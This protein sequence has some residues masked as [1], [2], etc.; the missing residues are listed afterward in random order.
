MGEAY[1]KLYVSFGTKGF[2]VDEC[3]RVLGG[4]RESVRVLMSRLASAGYADRI[5][6]GEYQ[7]VHPDEI[8][9]GVSGAL[10]PL[11]EIRQREYVPILRRMLV[12]LMGA[13]RDRLASVV[14]FGSIARGRAHPF[15]DVDVLVV[16]DGMPESLSD[17]AREFSGINR[18]L[19]NE[20]MKL[21]KRK[22]IYANIEFIPFSREEAGILRA[23]YLDA[24][25]DSIVLFDRDGFMGAVLERLRRRLREMGARRIELPDGSWYWRLRPKVRRGE[26]VSL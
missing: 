5:R 3:G 11:H 23:L 6:R 8:V 13:F 1:C 19:H 18:R 10:A 24:A 15:S 26:V 25:L 21:W 2:T 14:L 12:E 9:L 7:L 20:R 4:R 22:G 17:R 16:V